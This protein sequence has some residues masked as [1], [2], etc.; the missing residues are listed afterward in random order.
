M[1]RPCGC[2]GSCGC[3]IVGVDGIR[4]TGSGSV[5]DPLTIGLGNPLGGN[6]CEAVMDCVGGS[7]GTGLSYNDGLGVISTRLSGDADNAMTYGT[8][9]GLYS[10]GT[11]G[12]GGSGGVTIASLA[13]TGNI[14]GSY[15]A[16]ST[17]LPEGPIRTYQVAMDMDHNIIHVP[18]RRLYD[19]WLIASHYRVMNNYDVYL[20]GSGGETTQTWDVKSFKRL[21]Y[22]PSGPL[23]AAGTGW[24][25]LAGY[26]GMQEPDMGYEVG[27]TLLADVF[28][29]TAK[30][31]VLYLEIKD[32][33]SSVGDTPAPDNTAR[34][35]L[36]LLQTWGLTQSVIVGSELPLAAS[37]ADFDS[38]IAGLQY[39][40]TNGVAV[41]AHLTSKAMMDAVTPASL[42]AKGIPWVFLPVQATMDNQAQATAYKTAGLQVMLH[43]ACRHVHYELQ[44]TLGFR[45]TLATDPFYVQGPTNLFRYRK[46]TASWAYSPP[47]YGRHG[48]TAESLT[49]HR[50]FS[51]YQEAGNNGKVSIRPDAI[52]PGDTASLMQSGYYIL[53]G[54]QCPIRDPAHS[55]LPV[56]SYGSPTNY[57]IEIGFSWASLVAD[58]GRWCGVWFCAP[59]DQPIVEYT[60]ANKYTRGY[61]IQLAQ[62]GQFAFRRYDGIPYTGSYPPSTAPDQYTVFWDSTW[63]TITPGTE[64][65]ILIQVRPGA[66]TVGRLGSNATVL[67]GRTFNATTGGGDKWR[68]PYFHFGRHFYSTSDATTTR[69][70]NLVTRIY[71]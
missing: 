70:H 34:M 71:G 64:Y 16:G 9:G 38:I 7:L 23:N 15:G 18:V 53:A 4:A 41:A 32:L 33:G 42:I 44:R 66:I 10:T 61:E 62:N 40:A 29:T 30:R 22:R 36:A 48:Y 46:E 28:R 19:F 14:G 57:D 3:T 13:A 43:G 25:P 12:G 21:N 1:A 56:G 59:D 65:R 27:G 31:K 11:T 2:A 63:G 58:R 24:D 51:G 54:E 55:P 17:Q 26:F 5:R 35:V 20:G 47:D 68:G 49:A 50:S 60:R 45:G 39:L 6:G 52:P 67:N 69:F 37:Q 8:D